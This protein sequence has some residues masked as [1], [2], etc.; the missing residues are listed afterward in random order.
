M[1]TLLA[2]GE[3]LA[4][5]SSQEGKRL[6]NATNLK[7]HYG[8][9]EANVAMNLARLGHP[10]KYATKLPINSGLADNCLMQ[11]RGSSVDV[12]NVIYGPGRL[13]SYFL[14][15]G[16]GLRPTNIIYDRK[17]S[18]ISLM[19]TL[20]WDLDK[21]FEDVDIF[22]ITGVTLALSEKWHQL[23][24]DL[25]KAAKERNIKISFDMNYR[26]TMW[27][28]SEAKPTYQKILPLVDYLSASYRD[29][30]AFMDIDAVSD[31]VPGYYVRQ[32]VEKYPNIQAIYGT[33]RHQYTP[34]AYQMCGFIYVSREDK[35]FLSK[36]YDM[37][38]IVDRVG[39]GDSFASGI[40]DGILLDKNP[41]DSVEF[42]MAS[43]ALKHTVYGD[44]NPFSREEIESFIKNKENVNR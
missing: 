41:Q 44:I 38:Q 31:P 24:V 11:L 2:I 16:V 19:E 5:F 39:S 25:V 23:G 7:L 35:F 43:S 6:L 28:Y 4:R 34:N 9:A 1:K 42:A 15:V 12:S 3:S 40:I 13:G 36:E 33:K 14:E 21:L 22:H 17:Y 30:I 8:G 27:N 37:H 32:M 20:E 18:T 26:Q 10:V 29:A